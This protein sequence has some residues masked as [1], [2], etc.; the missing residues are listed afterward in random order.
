MKVNCSRRKVK[1]VTGLEVLGIESECV[2]FLKNKETGNED[3]QA[4]RS[5]W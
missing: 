4:V 1:L 2:S 5:A 3:L